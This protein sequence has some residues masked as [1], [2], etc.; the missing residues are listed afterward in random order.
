MA[1]GA[2]GR[3][4][5]LGGDVGAGARRAAGRGAAPER[6]H[7]R[8]APRPARAPARRPARGRGAQAAPALHGRRVHGG[9]ERPARGR[10]STCGRS[11]SSR[12]IRSACSRSCASSG[13]TPRRTRASRGRSGSSWASAL[14]ATPSW[15]S[16]TN[17]VKF[18][19]ARAPADGSWRTL[20]DRAEVTRLGEGL[21]ETGALG[22]AAMERTV[23][24]I[25]GMADE[26][27]RGGRGGRG[28][29]HRGAAAGRPNGAA[30]VARCEERC[31]VRIEV[32]SGEDEARLAYLAATAGARAPPGALAVFDTRRRQHAV[33]V[34]PRR[35]GRRAVQR[36]GRRGAL[37]R[38]VRARRRRLGGDARTPRSTRSPPTS[39]SSTAGPPRRARRHGRRRDQPRRRGA[40]ARD[41]TTPT[42]SRARCSTGRRSTGSSSST[43]RAAP[44]ERRAIVGL[45]PGRA[46]VILA[47]ACIVRTVLDE[48]GCE[49]LT[50]SDRGLRHGVLVERFGSADALSFASTTGLSPEL[51]NEE[52]C[53]DPA[54]RASDR[55]PARRLRRG[56]DRAGRRGLRRRPRRSSCRSSTA[57]PR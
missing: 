36:R 45:Q 32:I 31:G 23:E 51:S 27:R 14:R 35:P 18:H 33:H 29:R 34:R 40:R 41:A 25:A 49:S 2:Q 12:R 11:R 28:G 47:G 19:L 5:A 13:S 24:A 42:S 52:T 53:D 7:A 55:A 22:A 21:D 39:P 3:V 20:V 15:T 48:L 30:F 37:H 10:A 38:A 17:S 1:P 56:G 16:G 50:V 9:G 26:A 44:S 46:E 43:G 8:R 6:R 54:C 4:P 57:V